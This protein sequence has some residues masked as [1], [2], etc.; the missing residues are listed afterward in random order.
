VRC[1]LHPEQGEEV[2]A[3]RDEEHTAVHAPPT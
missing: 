2:V 1:E 3:G